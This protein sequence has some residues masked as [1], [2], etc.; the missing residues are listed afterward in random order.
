M[1]FSRT[2]SGG[3]RL[4]EVRPSPVDGFGRRPTCT[5]P[6]VINLL[7]PIHRLQT[8]D[9]YRKSVWSL[10]VADI[11]RGASGLR[12]LERRTWL[13]HVIRGPFRW[14]GN[15]AIPPPGT[16][17]AVVTAFRKSDYPGIGRSN[18]L[19]RICRYWEKYCETRN[20]IKEILAFTLTFFLTSAAETLFGW[21][22]LYRYV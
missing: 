16:I 12:H 21:N 7:S 2:V 6:H 8:A 5:T 20:V 15:R 3:G 10:T 14:I 1:I 9:Q 18:R 22:F 19:V 11:R 17:R 13:H 4:G